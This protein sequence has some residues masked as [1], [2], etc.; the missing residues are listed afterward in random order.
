L[1]PRRPAFF[2]SV[3]ASLRYITVDTELALGDTAAAGQPP[4]IS[5]GGQRSCTWHLLLWLVSS[6]NAT[7][8]LDLG[9]NA[10]AVV[11]NP[12]IPDAR[13]QGSRT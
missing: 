9:G 10:L 4:I 13:T 2:R 12:V 8:L 5:E 7:L 6:A 11:Q 1:L 3:S